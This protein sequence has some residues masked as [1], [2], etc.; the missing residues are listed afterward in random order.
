M[1]A[2]A[3][4]E[5]NKGAFPGALNLPLMSDRERE[6]VGTCYTRQG[7][8][9]AVALGHHLVSGDTKIV[10]L[11]AWADFARAH[12]DGY[13]YC[14]RGGMRSQ[15]VQ[16]WLRSEAGIDYPRVVGGYKAMRGFLL[17]T[18]E[19][20][21]SDC[22]YTVLGGLTGTGKTDVLQALRNSL[23]L[24]HHAHHRGSSFG[25]HADDQPVQIDFENRLAID[26]LKKRHAGMEHFIVEDEGQAIGRCSLPGALYR[27]MQQT[28]MI[29]LEDSLENRVNRILRDYIVELQAEFIAAHGE[30]T[31]RQLHAERLQ[32]SLFRIR[33]RL[34]GL[35]YQQLQAWMQQALS[36]HDE[37]A[38]RQ[39]ITALLTQ[40]YDPMYAY[41][42]QEKRER[43]VFA[44]DQ[45]EVLEFLRSGLG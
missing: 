39:W 29:W 37:D 35:R 27:L 45:R 43:I 36:S 2:R 4:V 13:L 44:G 9:A 7:P 23:D 26:L 34:G 42:R 3:P 19:S 28:P 41:Q 21:W 1:D 16:S 6:L 14:F 8:E 30:E 15:I 17:G 25:K 20:S 5:F 38:H 22:R 10:R 11:A 32:D 31:G 18:L 24:E 33:K 12:P 40:Y